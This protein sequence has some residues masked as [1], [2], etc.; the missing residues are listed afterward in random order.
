[1]M[2]L[3]ILNAVPRQLSMPPL[4]PN[5]CNSSREH[6]ETVPARLSS[7]ANVGTQLHE[8]D[9]LAADCRHHLAN[10]RTG[11]R[12]DKQFTMIRGSC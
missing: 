10:P 12:R 6:S 3:V 2:K 9:T 4:N 5:R 1:M 7:D 11:E 8:H